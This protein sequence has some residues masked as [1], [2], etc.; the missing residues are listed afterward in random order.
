MIEKIILFSVQNKLLTGIFILIF[1]G[2]GIFSVS[3]LSIDALPDVTNNQVLV[4]TVCPNLATQEVEQFITL[5]V[6][7]QL[8]SIPDVT[9]IRSSSRSGLS[10]ITIVFKDKVPMNI[11]RQQISERLKIAEEDLPKGFGN[12]EMVP[13]TT[14]LGEIYQYTL[15]SKKGYENKYS[16]MELRTIQDW[17]I[18]KQLL[19]VP[20]V[21]DVSTIGGYLKQYEVAVAPDKLVSMNITLM[22]VFNALAKNNQNTGGSYIEKGENIYF[23]RGE[24]LIKSISDIENVVVK[25]SNGIPIKVRNIASVQFGY[26]PRF[27]AMT[28]NGQGETVGAVVLMLKGENSMKVIAAVKKRMEQIK[29]NLP[30][31]LTVETF[32]DRSELIGRTINTV[33]KNLIEGALI[34]IFVLVIFLGNLRAGLIV[35]SVIPLS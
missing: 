32:L 30:E 13:P 3:Q 18:R 2:V 9:E 16:S 25:N 8:K 28:R 1:I 31:G 23:I 22:D 27:G 29:K 24:G 26:A 6:E 14:G 34:V 35:A 17:I 7:T 19:G 5:P 15:H 10:T 20:G 33:S 12:P 4:V 21:V 11:A